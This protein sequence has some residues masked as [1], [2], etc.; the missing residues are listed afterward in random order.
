[1]NCQT[2]IVL[3]PF[4]SL[5]SFL[6]FT[7]SFYTHGNNDAMTGKKFFA[8][9]LVLLGLVTI[10][11]PAAAK[12]TYTVTPNRLQIALLHND[13]GEPGQ[14]ILKLAALNAMN[15]CPKIGPISYTSEFKDIFLDIKIGDYQVDMADL[16][17]A[18]HYGCN[19]EQSQPTAS[20]VLSRDMLK[21]NNTKTI[22][23]DSGYS[24]EYYD[25]LLT[26][27]A[28]TLRRADK[29]YLLPSRIEEARVPA[30]KEPLSLWFYPENTVILYAPKAGKDQDISAQVEK[31]ALSRGLVPLSSVMPDFTSPLIQSNYAYYVDKSGRFSK[32]K[33]GGLLGKIEMPVEIYGLEQNYIKMKDLEIFA[34]RPGLYE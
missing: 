20:I 10:T 18:P 15:G 16:P 9:L 13:G 21:E 17:A 22:R 1:M 19:Q 30:K 14:F 5:Q 32:N 24:I 4:L 26:D 23:F 12:D 25:V 11:V 6:M 3:P 33:D 29:E 7:D 34:R 31:L 27:D 2:G 8:C 28:I